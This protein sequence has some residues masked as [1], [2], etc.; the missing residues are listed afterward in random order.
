MKT[1]PASPWRPEG[2]KFRRAMGLA[3]PRKRSTGQFD[4]EAALTLETASKARLQLHK[5]VSDD[6]GEVR[7]YCRSEERAHKER[8]I[9]ERFSRRFEQGLA[10]L[11]EGLSR[12]RAH[13]RIE[14]VQIGRLTGLFSP[15]I[16]M[17]IR[18]RWS[19]A[20]TWLN[21]LS[22]PSLV[23]YVGV[24]K[25]DAVRRAPASS[26]LTRIAPISAKSAQAC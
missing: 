15:P 9:V 5:E 25:Q 21:T 4:P 17:K 22:L 7:L 24:M 13:T 20:L 26:M 12:P 10:R 23:V 2:A 8:G 18:D 6:G 11:S 16:G 1:I 19:T 3:T 14:K